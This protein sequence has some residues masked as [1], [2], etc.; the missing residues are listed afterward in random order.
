MVQQVGDRF[1]AIDILINNA[2]LTLS[3]QWKP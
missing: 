1:G 3:V 2:V